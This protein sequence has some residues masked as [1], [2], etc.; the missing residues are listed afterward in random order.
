MIL[1]G[2]LKTPII[3]K[4]YLF[5][6]STGLPT[7]IEKDSVASVEE[8]KVLVIDLFRGDD[9]CLMFLALSIGDTRCKKDLENHLIL[10]LELTL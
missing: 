10:P 6:G 7:I 9:E 1:S 2:Q 3:G 5:I 8:R 4:C